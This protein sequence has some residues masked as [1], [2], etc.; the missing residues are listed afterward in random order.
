MFMLEGMKHASDAPESAIAPSPGASAALAPSPSSGENEAP[1][2][3]P[4]ALPAAPL[5]VAPADSNASADGWLAG[6]SGV[7]GGPERARPRL[8]APV[9]RQELNAGV[10]RDR[11][12]LDSSITGA[13][14]VLLGEHEGL[15]EEEVDAPTTLGLAAE[16]P[17][18]DRDAYD[19][20]SDNPFVRVTTDP[21]STFSIDVDTASYAIV[22]RFLQSGQLPPKGAVRIEELVNYFSYEYPEPPNGAPFAVVADVARAPWAKKHRLVRIGL[23]A[24]HVPRDKRPAANLVFLIDVSGSMETPDKLPLVKYGLQ[25]LAESLDERDRVSMVVYAGNSG[26]VLD[27]TRGD[28]RREILGALGRLEAGGSTNGGQ[29]IVL[30]YELARRH[31]VKGGVNRV[32]L[33]TDGDFNVGVTSQSELVDLIQQQATSGV[34]LSVL[35]FGTGNYQD[36]TLEKLADKG[37]GNYAYIDDASEA[38]KVLVE[39][40]SGTLITVA[41]DVKLQ[42]EFNPAKVEAFRLIGY[43]NRVLA[44]QDFNDDSKDAGEIGADHDVTA[45]YEV[46]PKGGEVPGGTVDALRYQSP[47]TSAGTSSTTAHAGELLHVKLRYQPPDGGPSA[48]SE[49]GVKTEE[50][51]LT[52]DF[53]F[54][55]AVAQ[56]GMLLRESPYR[57]SSSFDQV[58][59]LAQSARVSGKEQAA[60]DEF[61]A[62]VKKARGIAAG[63]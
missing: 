32:I 17:P 53:R 41:K 18:S 28:R 20:V 27:A 43:E 57:G 63:R 3:L 31:F 40:T 34:F 24:R 7:R 5:A 12:S 56:F 25:R 62:L 26:L 60:R 14:G 36:S 30:A 54:A 8:A 49:L 39:Q 61:I 46:I 55:A 58:L 37:N 11:A 48:L 13:R 52:G 38:H 35:G 10:Q 22:R 21:R 45:L 4:A 44:H 23:K 9:I 47:A 50:R 33:A 51:G 1:L 6:A 2:G 42:L 19:A 29:G 16:P 15:E 59:E